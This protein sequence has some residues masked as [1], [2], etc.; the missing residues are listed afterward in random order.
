MTCNKPHLYPGS[1]L[2]RLYTVKDE[3]G[4]LYD[5]TSLSGIITDSGG[6]LQGTLV[7]KDFSYVSTGKYRLHWNLPPD[8]KKGVW[9][10]YLTA[11]YDLPTPPLI[12]KKT[13]NFTV[14]LAPKDGV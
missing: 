7:Y 12:T 10:I 14:E 5:P 13:F 2:T 3:Y 8:A 1:S 9:H 6:A 11:V 4:E